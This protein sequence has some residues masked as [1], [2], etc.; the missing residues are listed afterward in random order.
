MCSLLRSPGN[1]A[2]HMTG[3]EQLLLPRRIPG[4]ILHPKSLRT[5]KE[6]KTIFY[7]FAFIIYNTK[8][9]G[10]QVLNPFPYQLY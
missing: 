3:N 2:C 6:K 10:H 8:P 7:P 1:P 5:L 4:G 9:I